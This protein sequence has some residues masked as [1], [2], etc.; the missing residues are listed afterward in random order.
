[1]GQPLLA[2]LLKCGD[3]FQP[4]RDGRLQTNAL[5]FSLTKPEERSVVLPP[6]P[7]RVGVRT[8]RLMKDDLENAQ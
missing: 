4:G 2:H 6:T 1:L 7:E 5:F 3:Q 8:A